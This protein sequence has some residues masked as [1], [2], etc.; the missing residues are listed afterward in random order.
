M[1]L[2]SFYTVVLALFVMLIIGFIARKA[3]IINDNV[4]KGLSSIVLKIG[5]PFMIV[6]AM[7]NVEYSTQRLKNGLIVLGLAIAFHAILALIAYFAVF[8]YKSI[9]ERKISEFGMIFGNCGF[10]GF[11][12]IESALGAEGL[13]YASF[14][15]VA[16]NLFMW[17]WGIAILAR[18]R[19]DIKINPKSMLLNYGTV[20]CVIGL[21]IFALRIPIPDFVG[22]SVS[23][24]GN[25][26]TPISMLVTGALIATVPIKDLFCDLKVYYTCLVK[27]IIAPVMV[28]ILTYLFGF[29]TFYI[30]FMAIMFSMPTAT[31]TVMFGEVYE[32]EKKRSA[33][34]CGLCSLLSMAT[35][36]ILMT[37]LDKIFL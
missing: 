17:T 25:I 13:F 6:G 22:T 2:L 29:S 37:I 35:M 3:N 4:S 30:L 11:P 9:D 5:Q 26:C 33:I 36:P 16:F 12:L 18:G 21:L 19:D 23:Y 7:I 31:S 34:I 15:I 14:F 27:L 24:L 1:N 28:T 32:I 10:I 20:P 8:K